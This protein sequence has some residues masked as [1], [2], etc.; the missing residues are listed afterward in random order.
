LSAETAAAVPTVDIGALFGPPG[1]GRERTDNAIMAAA[2][3]VGFLTVAGLAPD[4]PLGPGA[5]AELQRIFG[6]PPRQLR[7]LWRRKFEP[8]N[9]NLY[10]GFFPLQLGNVTCKE[11]ID[12]GGDVLYGP[13]VVSPG[14]PLRERTPLPAEVV[15]PGW[16]RAVA[17]YYAAMERVCAALMQSIARSLGLEEHFFDAA[18]HQGLSTLRLIRY[19]ARRAD[20]LATCNDPSVWVMH[21]GERRYLSGAPHTDSGFM[22][23]LACDGVPGLQAR[24]HDGRWCDVSVPEGALGVNFGQ[25]L[26]RWSGGRIRA[27]EHRVIGSGQER[28]SIPFFYEA[29]AEAEIRPLPADDPGFEPFLYGDHL[30]ARITSFVEFQGMQ[31]QRRPWRGV[32]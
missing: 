20:E 24:L 15:L 5:R 6:L 2:A 22:T 32:P 11:G 27:T 3:G 14:D 17:V 12:L 21:G 23:L 26:E 7:A 28:Y 29:R 9:A 8:G 1:P 25:V 19:P 13:D 31:G 30:R 10:R 18:F 16:G 4:V